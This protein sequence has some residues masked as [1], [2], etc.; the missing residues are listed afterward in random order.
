MSGS[1]S[2][3]KGAKD[4]KKMATHQGKPISGFGSG[5]EA[6]FGCDSK[7]RGIPF[8]SQSDAHYL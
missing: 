2:V 8:I 1:R 6:R 5:M 3:R 4:L 7:V